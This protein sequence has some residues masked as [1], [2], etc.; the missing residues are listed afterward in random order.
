M[1]GIGPCLAQMVIDNWTEEQDMKFNPP[2]RPR[3]DPTRLVPSA[4]PLE[5][6]R[7]TYPWAQPIDLTCRVTAYST[8]DPM[9][10]HRW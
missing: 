6:I 1:S 7:R 9:G 2:L 10:V 3:R 8:N 4:D 5:V